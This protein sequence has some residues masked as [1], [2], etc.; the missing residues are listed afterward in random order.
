MAVHRRAWADL[1]RRGSPSL[2]FSGATIEAVLHC[3]EGLAHGVAESNAA[4]VDQ[5]KMPHA[6]CQQ[7]SDDFAAERAAACIIARCG[8]SS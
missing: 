6:P 4:I 1:Q 2:C 8:E 7:A 3:E 5:I